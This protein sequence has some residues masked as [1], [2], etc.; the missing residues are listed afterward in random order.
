M[1]ASEPK[2]MSIVLL[3]LQDSVCEPAQFGK[4]MY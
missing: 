1:S 4:E 2:F 3:I